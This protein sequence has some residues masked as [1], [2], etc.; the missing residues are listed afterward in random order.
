MK[1]GLIL[2]FLL[3]SSAH[4]QTRGGVE[5]D[6]AFWIPASSSEVESDGPSRHQQPFCVTGKLRQP[7]RLLPMG[8]SCQ[9]DSALTRI[10]K[11]SLR[12]K[13]L[14]QRAY[15]E[16]AALWS[17]AVR[18]A[19][20]LVISP[21]GI[22]PGWAAWQGGVPRK[23]GCG[24]LTVTRDL[25]TASQT[26][27]HGGGGVI[28]IQSWKAGGALGWCFGFLAMLLHTFILYS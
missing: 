10:C 23:P 24:V 8:N 7:P 13:C 2:L 9:S 16:Q 1:K 27:W 19:E 4:V 6:C 20:L 21:A 3:F 11:A 25:S 22:S 12:R 18:G 15:R 26:S 28:P 17:K 14:L 5:S